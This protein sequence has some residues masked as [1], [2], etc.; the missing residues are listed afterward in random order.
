MEE[1]THSHRDH[2]AQDTLS[3]EFSSPWGK[4]SSQSSPD[5]TQEEKHSQDS[6]KL[7]KHFQKIWFNYGITEGIYSSF[8]ISDVNIQTSHTG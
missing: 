1:E 7:L 4:L 6:Q 3:R 8:N 5:G 2:P